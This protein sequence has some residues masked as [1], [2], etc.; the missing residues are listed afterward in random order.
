MCFNAVSWYC[1]M[2]LVQGTGFSPPLSTG[3]ECAARFRKK[4][5]QY[6]S[7]CRPGAWLGEGGPGVPVTPPL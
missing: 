7:Y 2:I 5:R 6:S 3:P 4:I 1:R